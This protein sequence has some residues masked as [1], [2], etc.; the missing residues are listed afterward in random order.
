MPRPPLP[1]LPL[2]R[3]LLLESRTASC[4]A[5]PGPG[6]KPP[7]TGEP[8]RLSLCPNESA[9]ITAPAPPGGTGRSIPSGP[10]ARYNHGYNPPLP[11]SLDVTSHCGLLGVKMG[12]SKFKVV[13]NDIAMPSDGSQLFLG[14]TLGKGISTHHFETRSEQVMSSQHTTQVFITR[15]NHSQPP[16]GHS[17]FNRCDL[18]NILRSNQFSIL[19]ERVS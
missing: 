17:S 9:G 10:E 19:C 6:A 12:T 15:V 14:P 4:E 16:L 18:C 3:R 8:P 2:P 11:Q 5:G 7:P 13:R 1:R